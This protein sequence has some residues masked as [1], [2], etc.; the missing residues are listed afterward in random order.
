MEQTHYS[1]SRRIVV[2]VEDEFLVRDLAVCELEDN[3][4]DV[5]EFD[6][7]DAA[8][9]YLREHGGDAALIVTDVQMPGS[10][11]GLQLAELLHRLWP[12]VPVL[13][14]SGGPLVDPR[15]LPACAGF[16]SKPWRPED[17]VARVAGMVARAH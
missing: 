3:G 5:V 6:C 11:N 13:I 16:M 17:M 4:F 14:T 7:A 9:P 2:V 10:L 15:R 8:L 12:G 1:G